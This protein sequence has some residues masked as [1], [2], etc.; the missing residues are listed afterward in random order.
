VGNGD[1]QAVAAAEI[2]PSLA[3][4]ASVVDAVAPGAFGVQVS[5][6]A[7]GSVPVH[8]RRTLGRVFVD[9]GG[10]VA[11]GEVSFRVAAIISQEVAGLALL[12]DPGDNRLSVVLAVRNHRVAASK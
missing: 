7:G 9:V 10:V 6:F 2:V 5:A 11:S 8:Q 12:A 4:E 1:S 3:N